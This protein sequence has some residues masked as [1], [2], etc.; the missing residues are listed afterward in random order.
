MTGHQYESLAKFFTDLVQQQTRAA[1]AIEK[2]AKTLAEQE[3][4]LV[5]ESRTLAAK[6]P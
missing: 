1:E 4:R 2:V 3:A 5:E 6:V